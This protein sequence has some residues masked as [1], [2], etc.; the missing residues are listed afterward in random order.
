M[1]SGP[2]TC[3]NLGVAPF[4]GQL[5]TVTAVVATGQIP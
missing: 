4:T 1:D 5:R 2:E 3:S